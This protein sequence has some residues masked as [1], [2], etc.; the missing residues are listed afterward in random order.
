M[1]EELRLRGMSEKTVV[2]YVGT[3]RRF[4]EHY[5]RSPDRLGREEV[6]GYLLYLVEECKLSAASVNQ[7]LSAPVSCIRNPHE[8]SLVS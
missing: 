7:A 4:A 3:V 5:R 2:S 8:S 6:R 1:E